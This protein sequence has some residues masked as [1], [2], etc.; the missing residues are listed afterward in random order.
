MYPSKDAKLISTW[1]EHAASYNKCKNGP[2]GS[3][4]EIGNHDNQTNSA[5]RKIRLIVLD[6]TY[7]MPTNV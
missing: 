5:E 4:N 6:G 7:V 1:K 3:N 2:E